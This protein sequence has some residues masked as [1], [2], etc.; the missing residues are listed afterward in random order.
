MK[1]IKIAE[2]KKSWVVAGPESLIISLVDKIDKNLFNPIIVTYGSPKTTTEPTLYQTAK[3][4]NLNAVDLPIKLK[5]NPF[6]IFKVLNLIKKYDIDIIHT[7]DFK[8]NLIGFVANLFFRKPI[9][10]TIHGRIA[11]PFRVKLYEAFDSLLIRFF[12]KIIVGSD[13]LRNKLV[14]SWKI[15][16][17]KIELIHNSVDISRF[18][19]PLHSDRIRDEFDIK[20]DE[21]IITTIGQLKRE[22]GQDCL[23]KA[24]PKVIEKFGKV[25]FLICGEGD[26][27]KKLIELAKD[28][29]IIE[30]VIFTGFYDDL[31]QV[32]GVSDIFITPSLM[33]SLPIVILEAMCAGLP[34]IGTRVGDIS[35]CIN[36]K[37]GLLI[38]P[39]NSEEISKALIE[40][41][42]KRDSLKNMGRESINLAREKFSDEVMVE[43]MKS[44]YGNLIQKKVN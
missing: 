4:L 29:K 33:E 14:D 34:I 7:H 39:G 35:F 21:I 5:Y 13:N 37:N 3:S 10:A 26:Y 22:K 38:E 36:E 24:I 20:K 9:I 40:L 30:K 43:K 41:L 6:I 8:S 1:K 16:P 32:L 15:N 44:V 2:L 28:L 31:S 42:E 19:L 12:D 27:K 11:T 25:R 18:N 23:L 17:K